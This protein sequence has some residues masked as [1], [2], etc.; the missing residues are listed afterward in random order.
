M[1]LF[2]L[3]RTRNQKGI[4]LVA[5]VGAMLFSGLFAAISASV[6]SNSA[7]THGNLLQATQA[8]ALA[9]A[10]AQWYLE[11][12]E[13]D[14]DWTNET[15]QTLS[16][17]T[18]SFTISIVSA[19]ATEVRFTSTGT[20]TSNLTGTDLRRTV[21]TTARKLPSSF[22]FAVYQGLDPGVNFSITQNGANPSTITGNVWSM[23]SVSVSNATNSV[24]GGFVFVPSTETVSGAGTY[25][26]KSVSSP[27]PAMPVIT[28]TFYTNLIATYNTAID[29]GSSST[30]TTINNANFNVSG[31]VVRRN[32]TTTGTVNIT[33]NGTLV[34]L[35]DT[36]LHGGTGLGVSTLNITPDVGGSLTFLSGRS[37][38]IGSDNDNPTITIN[39][40]C[41]FYSR[42]QT[43]T[44]Q[45]ITVRGAN[46]TLNNSLVIANRRILVQE[47]ANITNDATLFVNYPGSNTNN[48]IDIVGDNNVT[49]VDGTLISIARNDP[50]LRLRGTT[51]TKSE[52]QITGLVYAY[53]SATTG[54]CQVDAATVSGSLVCHRFN[55]NR[56]RNSNVTYSLASLPATLPTGFDSYVSE[57]DNSWDGL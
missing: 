47:G 25:T 41:S 27:F 9:N 17:G 23:G 34:V 14:T 46:T 48:F 13:N 24:T 33:G 16:L 51:T 31:T 42:A 21:T 12:L 39:P 28:T 56:I 57:E 19:A 10:G 49:S 43:A 45:L 30:D 2:I 22:R 7:G 5:V 11:G 55:S 35:R 40:G 36:R 52:N 54:Y 8:L 32:F 44:N 3:R 29:A 4:V 18:G 50:G 1:T 53:G 6:V 15:T 26:A 37:L 38:T 20:V